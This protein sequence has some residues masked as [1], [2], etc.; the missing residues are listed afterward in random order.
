VSQNKGIMII[1]ESGTGKSSLQR[2][3][4]ELWTTGSGEVMRPSIQEMLLLPQQPFHPLGD[5]SCQLSY[6]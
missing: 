1:G 3:I 5:L 6:Q 2:V 4:A